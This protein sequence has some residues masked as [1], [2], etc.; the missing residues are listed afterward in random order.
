MGGPGGAKMMLSLQY[1]HGFLEMVLSLKRGYDFERSLHGFC[2]GWQD[3][4]PGTLKSCSRPRMGSVFVFQCSGA[5]E[6]QLF[7]LSIM[8]SATSPFPL[9]IFFSFHCFLRSLDFHS[10]SGGGGSCRRQWKSAAP[11]GRRVCRRGVRQESES[12]VGEP[13]RHRDRRGRGLWQPQVPSPPAPR[14]PARE[15]WQK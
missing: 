4:F 8:D 10:F 9:L 3:G 13:G 1:G 6:T 11:A 14:R 7:L 15:V 5:G 12:C 2:H